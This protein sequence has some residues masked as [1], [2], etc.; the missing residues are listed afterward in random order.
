MEKEISEQ[1]ER[2]RQVKNL[3]YRIVGLKLAAYRESIQRSETKLRREVKATFLARHFA[4][5]LF[6]SLFK[7]VICADFQKVGFL[8]SYTK[9]H[10]L[11]L[12]QIDAHL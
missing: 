2:F 4:F 3:R 12:G 5:L 10:I 8:S 1:K 9:S 6:A 7:Y 11:L